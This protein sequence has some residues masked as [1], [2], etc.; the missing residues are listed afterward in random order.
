MRSWPAGVRVVTVDTRGHGESPVP[1]GPYTVDE[2]AYD[3]L[4]TLD[5]LGIARAAFAGLSLGGAV[6]QAVALRAPD[7]VASLALLC[8]SAR[9]A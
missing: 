3:V 7:R 5:D 6:G 9:F 2:L 1:D 4:D 8:T